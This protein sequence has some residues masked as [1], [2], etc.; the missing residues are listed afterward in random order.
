MY[1][2][3]GAYMEQSGQSSAL[4]KAVFKPDD[5]TFVKTIKVVDP[6]EVRDLKLQLVFLHNKLDALY[7]NPFIRF[8]M[9]VQR[10]IKC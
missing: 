5:P 6:Q 8:F 10:I 9:W 7:Q 2:L 4:G 1:P 3:N